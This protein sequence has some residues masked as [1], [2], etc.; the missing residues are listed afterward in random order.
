MQNQFSRTQLLMGK[1]AIETLMGSRVAVFGI[2]GV[3]G[4]VVE[5]L[6][7]SGVGALDIID[8]DKICMTNINRQIYA[9]ISTVGQYKVDVA[10][11]RILDINPRC[12]VR[13]YRM[14][15]LPETASQFDFTQYDY[16]VDCI[17][18]VTAKLDIIKKC[19][20]LNVPIMSSMGAANKL[21]P[22]A[23]KVADIYKTHMDPLARVM[24]RELKKLGIPKLK[25]VYSEEEALRPIDDETISCRFHCICPDKDMRKCTERR[26][27]PA[28]NAF[29]PPAA[30]LI[31]GGEVVKDLI[32]KHQT[33]RIEPQDAPTNPHAIQAH[34]RAVKMLEQY[35]AMTNE[36][37]DTLQPDCPHL[38]D[39]IRNQN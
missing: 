18:T 3:G 29:V 12:I 2:G 26:D 25:C 15:Y 8:D 9:L 39:M 13:K 34:D 21:D 32:N 10:E 27:I 19:Y 16:V 36:K 35:K 11:R 7:R 5:V 4:Y 38:K 14:F 6:A 20:A 17:D 28:S 1:P 30:G 23:F 33:M 31:I 24:R 22:T 37:K